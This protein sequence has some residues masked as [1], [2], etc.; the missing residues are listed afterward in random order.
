M[1]NKGQVVLFGFMMCVVVIVFALGIAY[2]IRE[3]SNIAMN[4]STQGMNC[5]NPANPDSTTVACYITDISPFI[6]IG[7]LIAIAGILLIGRWVLG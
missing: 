6:F 7:S 3:G 4:N 1:N 2:S 5:S